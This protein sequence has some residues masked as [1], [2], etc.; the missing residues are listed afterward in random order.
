MYSQLKFVLCLI[1]LLSAISLFG[2]FSGGM[3]TQ[4]DPFIVATATEL[5]SVRFHL[6]SCFLQVADIDLGTEQYSSGTGWQPLAS[7]STFG[8][9]TGFY[10]GNGYTIGN[11][12]INC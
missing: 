9:F 7:Y 12:T 2:Q 8:P 11:L 10:N 5:D 6:D 4:S 3:G 1:V